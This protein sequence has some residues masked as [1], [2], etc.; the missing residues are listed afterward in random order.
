MIK[1]FLL[2]LLFICISYSGSAQKITS[3]QSTIASKVDS[4]NQLAENLVRSQ[5]DSALI[6]TQKSIEL[7]SP[8]DYKLGKGIALMYQSYCTSFKGKYAEA[9]PIIEE[10][11]SFLEKT[12]N[13]HD[14]GFAYNQRAHLKERLGD[15]EQALKDYN[16]SV[17][18]MKTGKTPSPK[19]NIVYNALGGYYER[20]G[21]YILSLKCLNTALELSKKQNDQILEAISLSNI[22]NIHF[23]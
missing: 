20:R 22:G 16:K 13:K 5:T 2:P 3:N 10:S 18:Y 8:I 17:D 21:N 4:L 14:L 12:S 15:I 11:I 23:F 7:A 1:Y 6:L 19:L 9:L